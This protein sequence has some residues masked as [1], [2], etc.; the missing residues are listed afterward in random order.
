LW[1]IMKGRERA[2]EAL[3]RDAVNVWIDKEGDGSRIT[4]SVPDAFFAKLSRSLAIRS[5]LDKAGYASARRAFLVGDASARAYESIIEDG[6][7]PSSR[8][9]PPNARTARRSAKAR[10]TAASAP[11][12]ST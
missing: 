5:F 7:T 1:A 10:P 8:L 4:I 6:A 9:T 11:L 12:P 2:K 3:R